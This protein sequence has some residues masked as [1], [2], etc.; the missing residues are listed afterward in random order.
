MKGKEGKLME[1]DGNY[2]K[3]GASERNLV[4]LME[5][6]DNWGKLREIEGN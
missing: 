1:I 2:G 5:I 4:K 6:G 3:L